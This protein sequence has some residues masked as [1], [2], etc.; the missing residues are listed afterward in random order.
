MII[1]EIKEAVAKDF[2][3]KNTRQ[4]GRNFL[5]YRDITVTK[6]VI[7][8]AEGSALAQIGDTK[9]YAGVKIDLATPYVDKPDEGIIVVNCEL[10]PIAHFKFESGPPTEDSIELA[11]VVDRGLRS[12]GA[13][14]F[15]KLFLEE[16]KVL[17]VYVDLAVVDHSG[18]LTDCSYLAAMAALK[19][20]MVPKY[21]GGK[22]IKDERPNKLEINND[23][24]CT[25]FEK[26]GGKLLIDCTDEEEIASSGR[27]SLASC[28]D[29][30]FCAGQKSGS[31]GFTV[32]EMDSM[33]DMA[34]EARKLLVSKL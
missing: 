1:D 31:A 15:K 18:N 21:E 27:V 13:L 22:L 6:N 34:L 14:D 29:S 11:R 20:A 2:I 7:P 25:S 28:D 17:S 9:V 12:S 24:V 10:S 16:A 3:S 30:H 33:L 26:I 4:D 5:T 23:V 8:N 19:T 32:K